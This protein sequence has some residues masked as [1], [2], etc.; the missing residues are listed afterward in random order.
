M[1][2]AM[3]RASHLCLFALAFAFLTA[4]AACGGDSQPDA[5]Q[6]IDADA[7]PADAALPDADVVDADLPDAT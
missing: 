7:G 4:V 3:S 1:F 2:H 5:R 6:S